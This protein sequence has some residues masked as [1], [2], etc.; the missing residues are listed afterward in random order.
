MNRMTGFIVLE[1]NEG[2][3][4]S[5]ERCASIGIYVVCVCLY[6]FSHHTHHFRLLV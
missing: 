3:A 2:T 6:V 4:L 1:L 5:E